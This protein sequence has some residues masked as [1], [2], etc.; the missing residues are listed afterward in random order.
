MKA[1][2]LGML[3]YI[4]SSSHY[5]ITLGHDVEGFSNTYA[6][7]FAYGLAKFAKKDD[8]NAKQLAIATICPWS[9]ATRNAMKKAGFSDAQYYNARRFTV[10]YGLIFLLSLL[11]G[12][13]KLDKDDKDEDKDSILWGSL[14]YYALRALLDQQALLTPGEIYTQGSGLLNLIPAGASGIFDIGRFFYQLIGAQFADKDNS[15]FFYQ[16]NDNKGDRYEEG[17]PKWW[18]T[19]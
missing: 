12:G 4:Y 13:F 18:I 11:V 15:D 3:E 17:D 9:K 1:W 6:K 16:R 8:F 5:S 14:Y 7:M 2:A 19:F 10:A